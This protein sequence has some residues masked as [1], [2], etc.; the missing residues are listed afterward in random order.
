MTICLSGLDVSWLNDPEKRLP[1][2]EKKERID[3]SAK[4]S[5]NVAS[6]FFM[7][8]I[9]PYVNVAA[10]EDQEITSRSQQREF[11]KRTGYVQV[12]DAYEG[13]ISAE[14]D[15]KRAEWKRIAESGHTTAPDW[16]QS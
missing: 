7:A 10:R 9:N 15:A 11:E 6:P 1:P 14:N 12:G 2:R 16:V 3:W 8:D 13:Q 4:R 5:D